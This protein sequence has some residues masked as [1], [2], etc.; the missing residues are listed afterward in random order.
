[1][2]AETLTI[3]REALYNIGEKWRTIRKVEFCTDIFRKFSF[4]FFFFFFVYA[5]MG[6]GLLRKII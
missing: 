2:T 3:I 5:V 6:L 1:M 4:L